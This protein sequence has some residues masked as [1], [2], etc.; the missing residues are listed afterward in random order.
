M[1]LNVSVTVAIAGR[2]WWI[3]RTVASLTATRT[4][5]HVSSIFVVVESGAISAVTTIVIFLLYVTN[6][7]AAVN[8]LDVAAQLVVCVYSSFLSF[9]H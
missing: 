1:S 5:R 6:N 8:G 9:A 7:P 2:L 3:D 4:N